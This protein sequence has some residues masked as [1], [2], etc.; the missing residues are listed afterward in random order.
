MMVRPK[1]FMLLGL[2]VSF[3]F[4]GLLYG[5]RAGRG[6]ITGIVT[7]PA[8]AAVPGATV[9][10]TDET[11]GVKTAV[12]TSGDGN[13]GTPLLPLGTYTVQVEKQGFKM[14]VQKGIVITSGVE[15][16]QDA[17]LELGTVTQTVEVKAASSMLNVQTADVAHTLNQRYYQ[18]LPVV[19]GTDIRL[20]ESMLMAQPGYTSME[21]NGDP[22]FRGSAF[23]SRINGGQT[24]STE[25]FIDGAAFGYVN[26]H[27]ETHESTPPIEAIAEMRVD[28]GSF[29]AQY[30]HTSGGFIEYTTKSGTNEF[31]GSVY[32]YVGNRSLN[33]RGFFVPDRVPFQN[34]SYG[35]TAGGPVVIPGVYNGKG[36]TFVFGNL[37][38]TNLR[39]GTGQD[40]SESVPTLLF[41]QGNFSEDLA[42]E[43]GAAT[44]PSGQVATDAL[45]RPIYAGEIFNPGTIRTVTAGQ[46][47]PGNPAA[48]VASTGKVA[49]GSGP[50]RDGYGYDRLTGLPTATANIIPADDPLRS[51]IAALINPKVPDP[52]RAGVGLNH[53]GTA[54]GDPNGKLD[55]KT[56]LLRV[57]H[58]VSTNFKLYS[59]W[60]QNSR[61]A[62]RNCNGPQGCIT[63]FDP[64]KTPEKNTNYIGPGF[65][66]RISVRN[67][68]QQ[69][70]WV[71]KPNL[72]NHATVA[73][74]RWYMGGNGLSDNVGW[75]Q[76]LGLKQS[77]GA[78]IPLYGAD[79][80]KGSFPSL[81]FSGFNPYSG[82]GTGW[83]GGFEATNRWQFLDDIS[84]IKGKHTIKAGYEYRHHQTPQHGWGRNTVGSYNFNNDQ[85]AGFDSKGS[86][87][88]TTGDPY[89]SFLLGQV[90][91]ANFV[92]FED[93]TYYE[94]YTAGF[95][96]D[97]IKVT[98]KLSINI[99]L[100]YDYMFAR[101][102]AHDRYSTFDAS[103]P[104]P[105]A[106]GIP[107]ALIFA[108]TGPGR[109]GSRTFETP[110]TDNWGPRF[111][112]AYR[113]TNKDVIRGGYGMYY[114]SIS[115]NYSAPGGYPDQGIAATYNTASNTTSGRY[116]GYYWDVGTSCPAYLTGSGVSCGFPVAD[117]NFPPLLT[118][119]ANGG[120]PRG[121][122]PDSLNLPRYA[123]WSFTYQRQINDNTSWE[124][125]YIGNRG[126]RLP[127]N[128]QAMGLQ[129]N[130]MDPKYLSL[131]ASALGA[132]ITDATSQALAPIQALP[133]F[134]GVHLPYAGFAGN[135]TQALRPFPQY[136]EVIWRSGFPGG[137]SVYHSL[138]TKLERRF[139]NGLQFRVAYTWSKLINNGAENGLI[140]GAVIQN[141]VNDRAERG[142]SAD[143][144][145][146]TL[147]LAYT[148][149]LPFGKG[150]RWANVGGVA[151]QI[152]GGWNVAG[153][154]RYTS[155]RPMNIVM[156][157][158]FGDFHVGNQKRPDDI[159]GGGWGGG[160]FDPGV[161]ARLDKYLSKSGWADPGTLAFGNQPRTDPRVRDFK[162]FNED[163]NV[164]KEFPI[165]A[166]RVKLRIEIQF[167]NAFNR[168]YFLPANNNWSSGG[169][170]EVGGQGNQPRHIDF[171]AKL[172][173]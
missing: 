152:I 113:L 140:W 69:F 33:A 56:F 67:L 36:K 20:A 2:I 142:L 134:G 53:L 21:P 86:L 10:I 108:G 103:T 101:H 173:W 37:D 76:L 72:F 5:Q 7:D 87:L 154:H 11:T 114:G 115:F 164:F 100:R 4:A 169:F 163:L 35:V 144:V 51:Q 52:Q 82:Y 125:S 75:T 79:G 14:Y 60:F 98:P 136:Q 71:I 62:I 43:K 160:S 153:I 28:T 16:R 77:N 122:H 124:L 26:G 97:E 118:Q 141:P 167:G 44:D 1:L 158:D 166:E 65:Y 126:T 55:P 102:E 73:Y 68:H 22:M 172:S 59:T 137:S 30:G 139:A 6:I 85:T 150:K 29:S 64:I 131:G 145:P 9:T 17:T 40:F 165:K 148:Y 161:V 91:D 168:A 119:S 46:V 123:N 111:G 27:N 135:V 96:N 83:V 78:Y 156:G 99:G 54:F 38:I 146:H 117:V 47:D 93:T 23:N 81:G 19:M 127:M 8:G 162:N 41:K 12:S 128:G 106:G 116:P 155:G 31:H 95:V 49:T 159:G 109:T 94:A 48:G 84:W 132:P 120:N 133:S 151:N 70:D 58:S 171:G 92:V 39:T 32:E 129:D 34:N 143:D 25:S 105:D 104:N 74:D 88:Q 80:K 107:G 149:A 138:Q 45:G 89:A 110:E 15:Y 130:M 63:E 112:F 50:V 57:D 157:S 42:Y 61:P 147:I 90:N 66:Q 18:D 24:M 13:Y 170:G 121:V 3:A